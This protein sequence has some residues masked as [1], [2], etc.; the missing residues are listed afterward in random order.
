MISRRSLLA[1]IGLGP[2]LA[3]PWHKRAT[4]QARKESPRSD[5]ALA[6]LDVGADRHGRAQALGTWALELDKRTAAS[7]D[8]IVATIGPTWRELKRFPLVVLCGQ[9]PCRA[10]S[11]VE[12]AALGR[13]LNAGGTIIIDTLEPALSAR[14]DQSIRELMAQLAATTAMEPFAPIANTHVVYRSFYMMNAPAGRVATN[15]PLE[16]IRVG[17]RL[18]VIYSRSDLMGAMLKSPTGGYALACEP[19]G[20]AQRE[21]AMRLAVNL[22]MYALCLDYKDDQAHIPAL[23]QRRRWR[24]NDGAT[25]VP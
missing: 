3:L 20:E 8:L 22:A 4:A 24:A 1:F 18:G 15:A 6:V 10:L 19:G 13:Y 7:P 9:T 14:F 21:Q 2:L 12:L 17:P 16:G 25:S 23:L 11:P 5:V